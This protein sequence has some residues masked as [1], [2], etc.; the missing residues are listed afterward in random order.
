MWNALQSVPSQQIADAS[1]FAAHRGLLSSPAELQAF[2][3]HDRT[4][5]SERFR[6]DAEARGVPGRREDFKKEPKEKTVSRPH[7]SS[8]RQLEDLLAIRSSLREG[9][10]R[11]M[12]AARASLP[13]CCVMQ[14]ISILCI[15]SA[16]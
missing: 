12:T 11:C 9:F 7:Q 2:R 1:H 4:V 10:H 8:G 16:W 13:C 6:M 5:L 15:I 3:Q 14:N